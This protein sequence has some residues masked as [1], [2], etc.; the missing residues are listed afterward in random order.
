MSPPPLKH[1]N[2]FS[3]DAMGAKR[4][5][6]DTRGDEADRY[7]PNFAVIF[8]QNSSLTNSTTSETSWPQGVLS[9]LTE[10]SEGSEARDQSPGEHLMLKRSNP[11]VPT[12]L[13]DPDDVSVKS[14]DSSTNYGLVHHEPF[15]VINFDSEGKGRVIEQP[16]VAVPGSSN[17][18]RCRSKEY[19]PTNLKKKAEALVGNAAKNKETSMSSYQMP[20]DAS[21]LERFACVMEAILLHPSTM[22]ASTAPKSLG[23]LTPWNS[24]ASINMHSSSKR[25]AA[26][27]PTSPFHN[28]SYMTTTIST[29]RAF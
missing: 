24:S 26:H 23:A 15:Y 29:C 27:H 21:Y 18:K 8:R 7:Q 11:V 14:V 12:V 17:R 9:K 22:C 10:R 4:D 25:H 20:T 3:Q 19:L 2:A 6:D 5:D 16:V 28:R 1:C 13:S